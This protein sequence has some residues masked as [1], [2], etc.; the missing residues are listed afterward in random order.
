[1]KK[2]SLWL[3]A[4]FTVTTTVFA[5]SD[6][7]VLENNLTSITQKTLDSMYGQG[8]FV[9]RVSVDLSESQ[10]SVKYTQQSNAKVNKET[11]GKSE[12]V[13]ILPGV[14]ALKNLA[15][16][17]MNKMPFDSVTTLVNPRVK[18]VTVYILANNSLA[19]GQVKK[20]EPIIFE[21]LGL[22]QGRDQVSFT[23]KPF[24]SEKKSS[25]LD[26]FSQA[27][28]AP[29][30][31][32]AQGS[33]TSGLTVLF[34][35]I[36]AGLGA[37]FLAIFVSSQNKLAKAFASAAGKESS[38]PA[39][40]VTPNIELPK[41][42]GSGEKS[43]LSL[44][45]PKIKRFF[46]FVDADNIENLISLIQREK[47][48]VDYIGMIVSFL[49]A[50]LS[51]KVLDSLTVEEK[52]VVATMLVD[53]KLANQQVLEKL[54]AKLKAALE[55]YMGGEKA[56]QLVM[57]QIKSSDK[58]PILSAIQR[59]NPEAYARV[60]KFIVLFSDLQL[61]DDDDWQAILGSANMDLVAKALVGVDQ[62]IYQRIF[63]NLTKNG[64]AMVTQ[65][66]E[67]K[68]ESTTRKDVE[69]AQDYL[70]KVAKSLD[71]AGKIDLKSKIR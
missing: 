34:Y 57:E 60:R 61:L 13:Y 31:G 6:Q 70:I 3:L 41:Q 65:Y 23:F 44:K 11:G 39:V 8:N 19:K 25:P 52:A 63:N 1:M 38:G 69:A 18:K 64:K 56:F 42:S 15:P 51:A 33:S 45:M 29:S 62:D 7:F 5:S 58:R 14:P 54:E 12:Q 17:N 9:A 21:V 46:D 30:S 53:Q 68:G 16:D 32:G 2:Y 22:V 50:H 47:L 36:F 20:A 40:N 26:S 66:L 27:M 35:I 49:P 59:E 48:S 71:E 67:L 24:Y 37:A 43:E 55:C 28:P 4:L 10:Y